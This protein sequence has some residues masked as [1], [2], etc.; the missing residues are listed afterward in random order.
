MSAAVRKQG[1]G[2][3]P[4]LF[5]RSQEGA[6]PLDD[7]SGRCPH[8]RVGGLTQRHQQATVL[9]H[10]LL[11]QGPLGR[12]QMSPLLLGEG[13]SHVIE[14]HRQLEVKYR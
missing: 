13:H 3:V 6:R 2:R 8:S 14:R 9:Q 5:L 4:E 7:S 10:H 11:V 1:G 12:V